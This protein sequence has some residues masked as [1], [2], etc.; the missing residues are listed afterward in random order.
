MAGRGWERAE[1]MGREWWWLW[2]K[3]DEPNIID[4]VDDGFKLRYHAILPKM[5]ALGKHSHFGDVRRLF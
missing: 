1:A 3:E 4:A 2:E 5:M